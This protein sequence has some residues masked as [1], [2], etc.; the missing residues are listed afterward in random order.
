MNDLEK[1]ILQVEI[2]RQ[3]FIS[4]ASGLSP[5]QAYFKPSKEEW[6]VVENTEHMVW[7]EYGG[8][9]GI[10]RAIE[11]L[12]INKPAWE[13][14]SSNQGLSIEEII[15]KTWQKKEKVPESARPKWGGPI[16]F[17]IASLQNC[18][19][20][21]ESLSKALVGLD[22]ENIIYPHPISGPLNVPQ[23]MEFLR[24]HLERH[25]RQI[26]NIKAHPDFPK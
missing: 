4:A 12:K 19:R 24:F 11:G 2:A 21:L 3:Q 6:S 7:A 5:E 26:E 20:L 9:N 1:L 18:Q 16:D 17:W 14:V 22:I 15:E 8:I 10:W 23:R 13:G 25:Q